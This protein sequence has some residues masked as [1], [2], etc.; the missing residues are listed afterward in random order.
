MGEGGGKVY[1]SICLYLGKE[2]CVSRFPLLVT[3]TA[4]CLM[5]L[6]SNITF[7]RTLSDETIG[8][9]LDAKFLA[10]QVDGELLSSLRQSELRES[11]IESGLHQLKLLKLVQEI[12]SAETF[13]SK[14]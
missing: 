13:L 3:W 14:L 9:L 8:T 2:I 5:C 10:E 4:E 12:Y 11:G 6:E 7:L 1:S